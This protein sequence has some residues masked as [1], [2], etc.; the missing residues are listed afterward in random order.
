MTG[1]AL[2]LTSLGLIAVGGV[3]ALVH[4]PRRLGLRGPSMVKA[5]ASESRSPE[6]YARRIEAWNSTEA[7]PLS[8]T[9]LAKA[10]RGASAPKV[11]RLIREARE[12]REEQRE[13][14]WT[15]MSHGLRGRKKPAGEPRAVDVSKIF[16]WSPK[17]DET[18]EDVAE[19]R[20][21][22]S[23]DQPVV[24]SQLDTPR[25]GYWIIDGHHRVVEAVQRGDSKINVVIDEH[26]PRVERTGGAYTS[27]LTNRVNVA[28]RVG[29]EK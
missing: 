13:R 17:V 24:V 11:A 15:R 25:G 10:Y 29:K 16:A 22:R 2:F 20:T 18:I 21:S 8:I 23:T 4:S 27:V 3:F 28:K 6:E 26:L 9:T 1:R 19:G 12:A 7:K 5:I 14:H